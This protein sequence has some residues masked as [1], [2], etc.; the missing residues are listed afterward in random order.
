M[1]QFFCRDCAV[2]TNLIPSASPACLLGTTYQL[3]KFLKHTIP[4]SWSNVHSIFNDKSYQGYE[5]FIVSTSA[6][7]CVEIDNLGRVNVLWVAGKDIGVTY[8]NGVP[9][10]LADT[11]KVVMTKE[12]YKVHAYP[13]GSAADLQSEK[14]HSCGCPIVR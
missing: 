5:N 14:C 10:C 7:G 13:T 1:S 12:K 6:S 4:A 3:D 9:V 8:Q 2:S 11:V